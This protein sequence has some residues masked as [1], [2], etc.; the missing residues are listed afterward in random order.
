MGKVKIYVLCSISCLFLC[1]LCFGEIIMFKSGKR[2]EGKIIE[3]TDNYVKLDIQGIEV[4]YLND[5]IA[6][7]NQSD[8]DSS[9]QIEL[10]YKAYTASLNAP[11]SQK[12]ASPKK[13]VASAPSASVPTAQTAVTSVSTSDLSK[14]PTDYQEMVKSIIANLHDLKSKQAQSQ[15]IDPLFQGESKSATKVKADSQV[16][17]VAMSISASSKVSIGY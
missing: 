13:I 12:E 16:Y 1:N 6:A 5:E 7:I 14:L 8:S 17:P 3:Q 2:I 10:L 11:K 9:Q 15:K 4:I